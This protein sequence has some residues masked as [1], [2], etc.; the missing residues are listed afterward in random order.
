MSRHSL[1]SPP[2]AARRARGRSRRPS[3]TERPALRPDRIRPRS[4]SASSAGP[5]HGAA[6]RAE[7][8]LRR[9][10]GRAHPRIVRTAGCAAPFLDIRSQRRSA[11]A[12]RACS[13]ARLPPDYA[14]EPAASTSTTRTRN[15]DT[16]VVE[17]RSDGL[18]AGSGSAQL[19]F[20]T[21]RTPTT[22]A[23]ARVRARRPP[24]RRHGRRRRAAAIPRTGR[25][26]SRSPRQ[27]ASR[28]TSTSEVRGR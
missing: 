18:R 6:Q 28:S 14:K 9:R 13:S 11:A 24:L 1:H 16:R 20:A 25:R 3:A 2:L 7:P 26:T 19:F 23:A 17:Y 22:T 4:R 27:A 21:T 10:A 5:R 8:A 12:S 15:G